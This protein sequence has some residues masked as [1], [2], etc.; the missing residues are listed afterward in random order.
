MK[1]RSRLLK[2]F[3]LYC[4]KIRYEAQYTKYFH[5]LLTLRIHLNPRNNFL[6]LKSVV[7][8]SNLIIHINAQNEVI[9]MGLVDWECQK[10]G[11]Y[12]TSPKIKMIG[13]MMQN[14]L[15]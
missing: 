6:N 8:P 3:P 12:E 9:I 13:I 15:S 2:T 4:C 14:D 5:K 10:R 11:Y 1:N 7:Y